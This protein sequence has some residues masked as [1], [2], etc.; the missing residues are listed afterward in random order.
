[1]EGSIARK[2]TNGLRKTTPA[3]IMRLNV[4]HTDH[5]GELFW[6][7]NHFAM[8]FQLMAAPVPKSAYKI[9]ASENHLSRIVQRRIYFPEVDT[10]SSTCF[11]CPVAI[12]N[13]NAKKFRHVTVL[14]GKLPNC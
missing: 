14:Y 1:M 8:H 11:V 9:R 4:N 7:V 13:K 3:R 5:T 6:N 2:K 12:C 10:F